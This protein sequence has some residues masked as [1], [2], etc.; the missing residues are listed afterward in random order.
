MD[1][2]IWGQHAWF[3]MHS[4]TL[5]Y[6]N[7]PTEQDKQN[8]LNF[9]KNIVNVLPCFKC[10]ANFKNHIKKYP[11][12]SKVV[13]CRENLVK[14]L[15]DI[16]NEVNKMNGDAV[17][18]YSEAIQKYIN[19]TSNNN[20]SKYLALFLLFFVVIVLLIVFIRLAF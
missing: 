16:H 18:S 10:R 6:P 11:L 4:I 9:F 12:N 1:P 5:V 20:T 19:C 7:N 2:K 13:A 14:W 3:F 15:I 8:I 17:L